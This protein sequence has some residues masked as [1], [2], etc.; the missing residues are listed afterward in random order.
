MQAAKIGRD[1]HL[2]PALV[3][4]APYASAEQMERI[5]ACARGIEDDERRRRTLVGVAPRFATLGMPE[6]ALELARRIDDRTAQQRARGQLALAWSE[7][8]GAPSRALR[9]ILQLSFG[10]VQLRALAAVAENLSV[11]DA[12]FG[13]A[14]L[15]RET[16]KDDGLYGLNAQRAAIALC[17]RLCALGWIDEAWSA[18]A[19]ASKDEDDV[20]IR[21]ATAACMPEPRRTEELERFLDPLLRHIAS[22][23]NSRM[24]LE[25]VPHLRLDAL[26]R[27]AARSGAISSGNDFHGALA[28]A[29]AKR[30]AV[31]EGLRYAQRCQ[32][33]W[34]FAGTVGEIAS[35]LDRDALNEL[36]A[37]LPTWDLDKNATARALPPLVRRRAEFDTSDAVLAFAQS[38]KED[39]LRVLGIAAIA[40]NLSRETV[41]ALMED[42]LEWSPDSTSDESTARAE[43]LAAI[44]RRLTQLGDG[45][46]ALRIAR[47]LTYGHETSKVLILVAPFLETALVDEAIEIAVTSVGASD[48]LPALFPRLVELSHDDARRAVRSASGHSAGAL[49]AVVAALGNERP[50]SEMHEL[51]TDALHAM[52]SGTRD[53]FLDRIRAVLPLMTRLGGSAALEDTS[54][55][56][57]HVVSRWP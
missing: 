30:G 23:P 40:E 34:A 11:D 22:Y 2:Q 43:A 6:R 41:A 56:L 55:A 39:Q 53:G 28:I 45:A 54:A 19:S 24:V 46:S 8:I 3:A 37:E 32:Y 33:D 21:A 25:L 15:E 44:A 50:A 10:S 13:L 18:A 57:D 29:M 47:A 49:G 26:R 52:A 16:G 7:D 36:L 31:L 35:L 38:F 42:L 9:E 20:S 1:H 27:I 48:A 12:R 17:T 14:H 51:W 4:V 5:V